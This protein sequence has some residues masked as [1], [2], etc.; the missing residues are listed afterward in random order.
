MDKIQE[1]FDDISK[2]MTMIL[3]TTN[4]DTVTMRLVS[5]VYYENKILIFTSPNSNKY[6]DM[7]LNPNCCVSLSDT[8][9]QATA[10]FMGATMDD[11]NKE[12]REAYSNK[13]KGAFDENIDFGGHNAEFILF[14]PKRLTGWTYSSSSITKDSIPDIPFEIDL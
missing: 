2:E 12:L 1:F 13:F 11:K 4:N 14:E 6:K 7:K 9:M 8:F 5:P 3:A 10:M